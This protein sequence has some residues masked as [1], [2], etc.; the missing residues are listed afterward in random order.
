MEAKEV[1]YVGKLQKGRKF[2]FFS[3]FH[4]AEWRGL[5]NQQKQRCEK[6]EGSCRVSVPPQ[7]DIWYWKL[8][9]HL[10]IINP[11][12]SD[13]RRMLCD[14]R[15]KRRALRRLLDDCFRMMGPR[16]VARRTCGHKW[17]HKYNSA[18]HY[19]HKIPQLL[20]DSLQSCLPSFGLHCTACNLTRAWFNYMEWNYNTFNAPRHFALSEQPVGML[21]EETLMSF[22]KLDDLWPCKTD[23]QRL[24]KGRS[25]SKEKSPIVWHIIRYSWDKW[26]SVCE[27]YALFKQQGSGTGGCVV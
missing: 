10:P 12:T 20:L 2:F 13:L 11:K 17:S 25:Y 23:D 8:W 5:G 24:K 6:D 15:L 4:S 18:M 3:E 21:L 16:N 9:R 7:T 27:V 19:S 14:P 22:K 26:H 1:R